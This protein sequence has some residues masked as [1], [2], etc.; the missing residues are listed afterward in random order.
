MFRL[1]ESFIIFTKCIIVIGIFA[2]D[3]LYLFLGE[4]QFF[5]MPSQGKYLWNVGVHNGSSNDAGY[6]S[7]AR[8]R[9]NRRCWSVYLQF[10]GMKQQF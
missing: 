8:N 3:A 5:L 6:S 4:T 1:F 10:D 9:S 7:Y 2:G